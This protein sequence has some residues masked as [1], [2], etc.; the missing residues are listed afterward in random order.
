MF[1]FKYFTARTILGRFEAGELAEEVVCQPARQYFRHSEEVCNL[2]V[3]NG[4]MSWYCARPKNKQLLCEDWASV[5]APS[6][7]NLL[8]DAEKEFIESSWLWE[9]ERFRCVYVFCI[10]LP[11]LSFGFMC[12]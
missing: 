12:G 6:G 9:G 1:F 8:N 11:S 10:L 4:G 7:K 2:T 3:A 5:T